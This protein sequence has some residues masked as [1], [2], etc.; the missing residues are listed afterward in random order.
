MHNVYLSRGIL[1]LPTLC[2]HLLQSPCRTLVL[3]LQP[4]KLPPALLPDRRIGAMPFAY[5]L[6]SCNERKI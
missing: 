2:T 5:E 3:K 4:F 6:K 1:S